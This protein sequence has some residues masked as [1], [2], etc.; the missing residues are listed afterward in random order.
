M[1]KYEYEVM[2]GFFE[3]TTWEEDVSAVASSQLLIGV[4]PVSVS[5][6]TAT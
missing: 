6:L 3:T 4:R 5:E 2:K 1:A